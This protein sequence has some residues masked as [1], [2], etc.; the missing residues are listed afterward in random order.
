MV[1]Q[2]AQAVISGR[3]GPNAFDVLNVAGIP[4]Y[5]AT[6]GTVREAVESF[7]AGRLQQLSGPGG[8]PGFGMGPGCGGGYGMGWDGGMGRRMGRGRG[9][10]RGMGAAR[11]G[12]GG[13]GPAAW[14][15]V[16]PPGPGAWGPPPDGLGAWGAP[17]PEEPPASPSPDVQEL[18]KQVD[19]LRRYADEI[20]KRIDRMR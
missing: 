8:D 16:P 3:V 18:K 2:G 6:G 14:G 11:Q 1:N 15:P 17:P 5:A 20:I 10:G 13:Y 12:W 7:K 19:D 4:I 9:Y